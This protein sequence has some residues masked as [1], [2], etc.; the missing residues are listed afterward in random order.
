MLYS[1]QCKSL[2]RVKQTE[3]T[4]YG[5]PGNNHALAPVFSLLEVALFVLI[6]MVLKN[7]MK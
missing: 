4:N 3:P 1:S 2:S 7:I 6:R 5:K